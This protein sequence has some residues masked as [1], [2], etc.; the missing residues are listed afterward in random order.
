MVAVI[1][2]KSRPL[3]GMCSENEQSVKSLDGLVFTNASV[4][5]V[6][7]AFFV[8]IEIKVLTKVL[9]TEIINKKL[10]KNP[11]EMT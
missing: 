2:C 1:W 9:I 6:V 8:A 4:S 11:Q 10:Q 3:L 5:M 7:I